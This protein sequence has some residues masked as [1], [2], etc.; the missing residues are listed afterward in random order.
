MGQELLQELLTNVLCG[1]SAGDQS[2]ALLEREPGLLNCSWEGEVFKVG[3]CSVYT[4][5]TVLI[6][7]SKAGDVALVKALLERGADLHARNGLGGVAL[8]YAAAN[9]RRDVAALLLDSGA[10]IGAA[11]KADETPL[12]YASRY[13]YLATCKFL[14][15]RGASLEALDDLSQTPLQVYGYDAE[16]PLSED[17]IAAGRAELLS[18]VAAPVTP[19]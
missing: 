11:C 1:A 2:A 4:G 18:T 17:Q 6:A 13:G 3:D 14:V 8:I 10:D 7:A 19:S 16:P 15:S 12:H 5:D 9:D